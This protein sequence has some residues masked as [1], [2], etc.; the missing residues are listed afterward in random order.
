MLYTQRCILYDVGNRWHLNNIGATPS[1]KLTATISVQASFR[2][3]KRRR[4]SHPLPNATQT[5]MSS[6]DTYSARSYTA[7]AL[8][9]SLV[10]DHGC[11]RLSSSAT[12]GVPAS[13]VFED[14]ASLDMNASFILGSIIS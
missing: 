6:V 9:V 14:L 7:E 11:D 13:L 2:I 4:P 8:V 1:F 10:L 5:Y 12:C 3:R